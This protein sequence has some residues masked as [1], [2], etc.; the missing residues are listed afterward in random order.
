[1]G[2]L[3]Y[4][5]WLRGTGQELQSWA[6]LL[7]SPTYF[8][9]AN[10]AHFQ[11]SEGLPEDWLDQGSVFNTQGELRWWREGKQ[12][13]ALFFSE[14]EMTGLQ[15]LQGEWETQEK[16]EEVFL[17]DLAEPRVRPTLD[18]YPHGATQ[19]RLRA[20]V[21]RRDGVTVWISPRDFVSD[22]Q[23]GQP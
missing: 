6:A 5:Y 17:Q 3:V 10:S 1:M 21:Y 13:Q 16:D 2:Q 22:R 18:S 14:Q 8:W 19:G 15:P 23:E 4:A 12:Y 20:K 7:G 11:M 9:V